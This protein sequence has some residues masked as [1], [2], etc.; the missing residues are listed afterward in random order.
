MATPPSDS[1]S[2][3]T[4]SKSYTIMVNVVIS[5]RAKPWFMMVVHKSPMW[6]EG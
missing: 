5:R 2:I 6:E 3:Q 4:P 1:I